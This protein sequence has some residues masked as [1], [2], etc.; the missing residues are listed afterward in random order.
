MGFSIT[1]LPKDGWKAEWKRIRRMLW[2]SFVLLVLLLGAAYTGLVHEITARVQSRDALVSLP[3]KGHWVAFPSTPFMEVGRQPDGSLSVDH[4]LMA[5]QKAGMNSRQAHLV[6]DRLE[7]HLFPVIMGV[8]DP[9][10]ERALIEKAQWQVDELRTQWPELEATLKAQVEKSQQSTIAITPYELGRGWSLVER[11]LLGGGSLLGA[12]PPMEPQHGDYQGARETLRQAVA[13]AGLRMLR[14]G[15]VDQSGWALHAMT[16]EL[17][18][19]NQKM[20]HLTGWQGGVLGLEGR[21]ALSFRVPNEA[22]TAGTTSDSNP[23]YLEIIGERWTLPHEWFHALDISLARQA[24]EYGGQGALTGN[25]GIFRKVEDRALVDAW[26]QAI[27]KILVE[28]KQWRQRRWNQALIDLDPYLLSSSEAMA[29]AFGEYANHDQG[30]RPNFQQHIMREQG[31]VPNLAEAQRQS[32]HWKVLLD[33]VR[34]RVMQNQAKINLA[35]HEER[36][37]QV[38]H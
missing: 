4:L 12:L 27:E 31:W 37:A 17:N 32:K 7:A 24:F 15:L 9:I 18:N 1:L 19:Q 5:W 22:Q 30:D 29:F 11:R 23:D 8:D 14:L 33:R 13:A 16:Q 38:V 21:I 2:I 20:Q 26:N 10:T 28:E 35:Q 36:D 25:L 34:D 3:A 6:L